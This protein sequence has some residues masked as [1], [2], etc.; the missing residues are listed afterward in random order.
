ML[1][2]HCIHQPAGLCLQSCPPLVHSAA[3]APAH[4]PLLLP[5]GC[6]L[7]ELS[8]SLPLFPGESDLDQL[9]LIA[10]MLGPLPAQQSEW[11]RAHPL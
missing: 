1:G 8:T 6:L 11:Q 5:P 4:L 7:A 10:K 3:H 2:G 9:Y